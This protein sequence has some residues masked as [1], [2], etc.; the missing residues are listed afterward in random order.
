[1]KKDH[2]KILLKFLFAFG[3]IYWL[4]D[5]GK[6]NFD[7]LLQAFNHPLRLAATFSL[8]IVNML[9]VTW[10]W[11]YILDFKSGSKLPFFQVAKYNWIGLFFNSV[12]PGSV[13]GDIVKAFY[14]KNLDSKMSNRFV[15]SSVFI[16]RFVGLFGLIFLLGLF[17]IF[18]YTQLMSSYL[19]INLKVV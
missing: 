6:L 3:I 1:M 12:L 7:I 18:N 13:T 5:S 15:F 8:V 19:L 2:I 14:I 9:I 17:T 10:R 16:D 4:I 11:K